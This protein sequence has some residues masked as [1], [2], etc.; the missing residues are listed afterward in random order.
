MTIEELKFDKGDALDDEIKSFVQSVKHRR[1]PLVTG[2]MGRD[3][4]KTALTI[5]TQI[6][7]TSRH[8]MY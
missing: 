4:L 7:E 8:L 3:A 5:M 1:S 6:Q 2:Q